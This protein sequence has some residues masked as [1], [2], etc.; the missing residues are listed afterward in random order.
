MRT[1][2][3]TERELLRQ[4]GPVCVAY[5]LVGM[6]FGAVAASAGVPLYVP[7]V[8]SL[9]VFAGSAQFAALGIVLGGGGMIVATLT[10]LVINARLMGYGFA[11]S[12]ALAGPSLKA[13]LLTHLIS[14]VNTALALQGHGRRWRRK[15]L[16]LGGVLIFIVWNV[17]T[18]AGVIVGRHL[19]DM[20]ALGLDAVLPAILFGLV[21]PALNDAATRRACL[22]GALIVLI[23]RPWLPPGLPVIVS[24]LGLLAVP[25]LLRDR[26]ST[27]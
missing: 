3:K 22:A 21:R 12:R 8:S 13:L 14:D 26:R 9:T 23:T 19:A 7:I 2:Y 16:C 1:L 15:A 20:Q 4:L 11:V 6:S 10:G 18:V 27:P 5:T 17:A 24:L 25:R